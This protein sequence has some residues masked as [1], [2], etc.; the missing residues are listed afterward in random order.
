MCHQDYGP[1]IRRKIIQIEVFE[2]VKQGQPLP[3]WPSVYVVFHPIFR[4][5]MHS[6]APDLRVQSAKVRRQSKP[7]NKASNCPFVKRINPSLTFGQ[8]SLPFYS[9]L[10]HRTRPDPSQSSTL[11]RSPRLAQNTTMMPKCGSRTRSHSASAA[12]PSWPFL[13]FTGFV[14]IIILI[15]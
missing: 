3:D 2:A 11:I 9:R 7:T 14:V 13:K 12:R 6:V 8:A 10:Q 15:A 1:Y 4:V 5:P